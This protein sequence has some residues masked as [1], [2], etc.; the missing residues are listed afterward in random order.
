VAE[1]EEL[2]E[3]GLLDGLDDERARE[4]RVELLRHLSRDGFS[5]EEMRAAA[6]QGRLALLPVDRV[7][8][9]GDACYTSVQVAEQSGVPLELLTKLWRAL[10]F[11]ETSEDEVAY[12]ERD[13]EAAKIVGRFHG[14]GL[15]DDTLATI[16]QV[17]GQGMSRLAD[18]LREAVGEALLEPGDTERTLGMRYAEA[19]EQMVPMLQPLLSHVLSVHLR[20]QVKGDIVSQAQ[21]SS[22]RLENARQITVCFADLVGFT[23]LGERVPPADLTAA[24]RR[25]GDLAVEVARP[26]V[27][28]VKMIGDAAMLVSP[29]PEPLVNAAIALVQRVEESEVSMPPARAG[30]ATGEAVAQSGDWFGAPVNMASRVTDV[31]RPVSVLV[32]R[33]VRDSVR[34][35]FAWSFAGARRLKGVRNEVPLYRARRLGEGDGG[36]QDD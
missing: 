7:L 11:A 17:L 18:T 1:I 9:A 30:V 36:A 31:A 29:E 15:G 20:E 6:R 23:R 35:R 34:D 26:P 10:G 4:E 16:S 5:I 32:T 22:G 27:R 3:A 21:L 2:Q 33:P 25:L 24:A 19:A 28:L 8:G 13:L 14:A 12:D